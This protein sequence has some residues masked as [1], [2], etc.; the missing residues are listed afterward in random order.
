MLI[1]NIIYYFDIRFL[2]KKYFI[3][4]DVKLVSLINLMTTNLRNYFFLILFLV[5]DNSKFLEILNS[6]EFFFEN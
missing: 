2:S 1:L 3:Y 4:R 5:F 6:F